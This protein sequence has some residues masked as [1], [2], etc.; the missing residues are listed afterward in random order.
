MKTILSCVESL[1]GAPE[2][3]ARASM[4]TSLNENAGAITPKEARS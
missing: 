3:M 2:E 4:S 1:I